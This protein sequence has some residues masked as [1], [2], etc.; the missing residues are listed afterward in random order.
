MKKEGNVNILKHYNM[1]SYFRFRLKS[2]VLKKYVFTNK[3][4]F[5]FN[6]I[7]IIIEREVN[8]S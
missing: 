4:Y 6:D 2:L 7:F 5:I 8:Y 3:I 1:D